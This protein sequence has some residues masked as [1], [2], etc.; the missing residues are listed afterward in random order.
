V[1]EVVEGQ[2]E[3]AEETV[4]MGSVDSEDNNWT[5]LKTVSVVVVPDS[6]T[7]AAVHTDYNSSHMAGA[8]S[9]RFPVP[10]YPASLSL[11]VQH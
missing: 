8:Q 6:C 2:S 1:V 3:V 5:D 10:Y 7:P 4:D 9:F 11:R